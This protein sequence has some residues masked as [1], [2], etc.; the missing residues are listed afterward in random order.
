MRNL[1]FFLWGL[2]LP[3][4]SLRE[5]HKELWDE[6]SLTENDG[7]VFSSCTIGARAQQ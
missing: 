6:L 3:D 1:G 5:F 4:A 7:A 2:V